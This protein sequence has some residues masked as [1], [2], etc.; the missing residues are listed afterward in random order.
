MKIYF[1]T[2]NRSKAA[3]LQDY[4]ASAPPAAPDFE[5]AVF[6]SELF[7]VLDCDID[8]IVTNKAL[9]AFQRVGLPCVVEHSGLFMDALPGLPGGLGQTIWRSIGDRMCGFLHHADSRA[10]TARSVIGYC[11]GRRVTL[12]HG[13]TRG[14]IALQAQGERSFNWDPIFIPD[15][16]EHTYA[17]MDMAAKRATSPVCKA[18]GAF[19]K[20]VALADQHPP[21]PV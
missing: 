13:E 19:V 6:Q 21:Y 20:S 8:R 18:W 7:E 9:D 11:D 4:L 1:V 2:N 16:S 3:E 5:I 12:F 15:G 14:Q 17:E 10:A